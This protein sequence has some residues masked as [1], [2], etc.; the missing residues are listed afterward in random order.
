MAVFFS[1]ACGEG[2]EIVEVVPE[3]PCT[4][5]TARCAER[6][7]VWPGRFLPVHTTHGLDGAHES[8]TTAFVVVHG[9]N[10]NGDDYFERAVRAVELEGLEREVV[11]VAP[12]FQTSDDDPAADEPF[13]SSGGWKRGHLSS[14][15]GPDPRISSYAALDVLVD[16]LTDPSVFPNVD[17]VVVT[18]HS[19]G[20]QV[21]HRYA[22]ASG[23]EGTKPGV[24]FRYVVA[25]P[26]TYLYVGPE[27]W[28][29]STF[30]LPDGSCPDYDEWHYGLE[31]R[32]SYASAVPDA[33]LRARLVDRDVRILLGT[34]DTLDSQ[35]DVSCGAN[36][37]GRHRLDR[38]QVL[39]RFMDDSFPGHRHIEMLVPG[40]GHSSSS[41][42]ASDVG[43]DALFTR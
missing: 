16:R 7:E 11:V 33:T 43:R 13:W 3:G 9:T 42:Y 10:R 37:Q 19:A 6:V 30:D 36:L 34:A 15:D 23:V 31:D 5:G 28:R 18:G 24:T 14:T 8:I 41:M 40:V 29:G 25:N 27:R 38:G 32:N 12:T 20:G 17:R 21:A 22:A 1:A 26:S 35:L 2:T 4:E 39:V